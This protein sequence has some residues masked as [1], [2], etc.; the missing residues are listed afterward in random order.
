[1]IRTTALCG[2]ILDRRLR[3]EFG[4]SRITSDA[5]L[6]ADRELDDTLGLTDLARG[7]P[8]D[9]RRG[10]EHAPLTFQ[11]ICARVCRPA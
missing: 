6:L 2:S 9:G 3:L 10:K 7:V 11:G 4:A 5:G 1:V 8:S